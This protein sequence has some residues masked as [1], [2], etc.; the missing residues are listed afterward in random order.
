[1]EGRWESGVTKEQMD[2]I[3][4]K[5]PSRPYGK[6]TGGAPDL[7]VKCD[8]NEDEDELKPR[9]APQSQALLRAVA[10][11]AIAAPQIAANPE[12]S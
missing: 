8:A 3:R 1:M 12:T 6:G 7:D 11:K 2:K 9:V 4:S 10:Q 5:R